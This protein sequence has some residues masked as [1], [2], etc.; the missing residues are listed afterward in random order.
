MTN[1]DSILKSRD[2]TL[3]T[4]IHTVK[5]MVFSVV[6][7]RC[8]SWTIK[9]TE[10]QRIDAFELWFWKRLL[11]VPWVAKRSNQSILKET[12]PEYS[13]GELKLKHQCFGQWCK[14]LTHWK[15]CWFWERLR[16]RGE[17]GNGWWDCWMASPTQWTW[18]WANS[19]RY[20]RTGKP[21]VLQSMRQQRVRHDLVTEQQQ[22]N[23]VFA[24]KPCSQTEN[25]NV[26][27]K[28]KKRYCQSYSRKPNNT[29]IFQT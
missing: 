6:V 27:N 11:R 20:W 19:R 3:P 2:I 4:N 1:L 12:I 15:W 9:K 22:I 26:K 28:K 16:T 21:G 29:S 13:L 23:N 8:E 25:T 14:E 10:H 17:G 18:V 7:Y 24:R 5:A